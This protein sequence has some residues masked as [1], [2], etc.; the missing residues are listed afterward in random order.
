MQYRR[1][2][3]PNATYFFTAKLFDQ[4]T[5]L[6]IKHIDQIRLA[7]QHVKLK[8]PF[9][10]DAII[11]LPDHLHMIMTLPKDDANYSMRWR[12]IKSYFSRSIEKFES[13]SVSRKN[14][15]ERGIWQ[16]RFWEHTIRDEIDYE[17]HVNYIHYNP[18]K[19][20]YAKSPADWRY[21]S[22]HR[23]LAADILPADW[24][25]GC[26]RIKGSFGE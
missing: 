12:L 21:S 11:I 25:T 5:Q 26:N 4:K 7:I 9:K 15:R 17:N 3:I 20:G 14:K 2:V 18:V 24:A 22:I 13:I 10:I 1:V 19:H 23:Y 16:R 6:L 8:H